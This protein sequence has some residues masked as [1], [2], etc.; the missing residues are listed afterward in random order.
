MRRN[1]SHCGLE[2]TNLIAQG[3]PNGMTYTTTRSRF[4]ATAHPRPR[5]WGEPRKQ[6]CSEYID[7]LSATHTHERIVGWK[8]E[9]TVY[10]TGNRIFWPNFSLILFDGFNTQSYVFSYPNSYPT[11]LLVNTSYVLPTK[12]KCFFFEFVC[13]ISSQ[14][15]SRN[16]HE[17]SSFL[18]ISMI[19]GFEPTHTR[20]APNR[21]LYQLSAGN[22]I[23]RTDV[24]TYMAN[25]LLIVIMTE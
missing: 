20:Q 3:Q 23:Q 6:T 7:H 14:L 4:A 19:P 9:L 8:I 13:W 21:R 12:C 18:F 11:K 5:M 22:A 17:P 15:V 16:K 10:I 25:T 24:G 2:P 1:P